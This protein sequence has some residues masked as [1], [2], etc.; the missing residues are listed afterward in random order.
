MNGFMTALGWT[1]VDFVWQG[2]VIGVL[3]AA[4]LAAMR[5]AA[6]GPRYLVACAAMLACFAWPA[7]TLAARLSSA[8]A[9]SLALLAPGAASAAIAG[10]SRMLDLLGP[11]L[12]T[13]AWAWAACALALG[14]RM[15]AGLLWI[16]RH[17]A[18][19]G[20]PH[21]ALQARLAQLA[22]RFGVTREVRLR[23]LDKLASPIT[24]GW[25]RPVVLVPASL[26]TGMPPDLLDALLAHEMAHIKR[27]DYLVNLCQNVI[28]TLLFYHPA[29]WWI[30]K[31]VRDEREKIADDLA[32]RQL[33]E[34]R[35]LALALSELEKIQFSHHH[36]AQAANG[37]DL[38]VRIKRLIKPDTRSSGWSAF[39]PVLGLALMA[40]ALHVGQPAR[41]DADAAADRIE[42]PQLNFAS[43]AKPRYPA[44]SLARKSEGTVKMIFNVTAEGTVE[45]GQIHTSSGDAL[46]DAA[47][48]N[49]LR[50]CT[51]KP[52]TLNGIPIAL[53]AQIQYVWT[54]R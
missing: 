34:P 48:L 50:K 26:V 27:M 25:W 49:A 9:A 29:V 54:L 28:E 32:A 17:S 12:D 21:A 35:R 16:G 39:V 22:G 1:L 42:K 11:H 19:D 5:R 53:Q 10:P 13:I 36:L 14:T 31:Q 33:G 45:D 52:G 8:E 47:A 15:T 51:F 20:T 43:C 38:M 18:A 40:G 41:A 24:A 6:P 44:E 7:M 4:L 30:S 37:G 23:V 3:A 2:A 46:L